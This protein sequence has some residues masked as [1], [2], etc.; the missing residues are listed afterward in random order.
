MYLSLKNYQK[1]WLRAIVLCNKE[2][3][4]INFLTFRILVKL[5]T[6]SGAGRRECYAALDK[7]HNTIVM[8]AQSW[9]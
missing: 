5:K 8:T 4:I 3:Q 2:N 7:P 9:T 6:F 1:G